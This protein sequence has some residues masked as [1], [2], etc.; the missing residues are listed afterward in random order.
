MV[1]FFFCLVVAL[2]T[3]AV[4]AQP[5]PGV[6]QDSYEGGDKAHLARPFKRSVV[7]TVVVV[8]NGIK[9]AAGKDMPEDCGH[10]L[11]TQKQVKRYFQ[12][13]KPVS[14]RNYTHELDWSPCVANGELTL[15]DG[16][17]AKWGVQQYGLGWLYIHHHL[18]YF[19]C[20]QCGL[21]SLRPE[22]RK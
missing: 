12:R 4:R 16:R 2:W 3:L 1:K 22:E 5:D 20:N 7:K 19:H 14:Y 6:V 11:V 15:A 17:T 8:E 13:A 18:H 9:S 10:F 21:E